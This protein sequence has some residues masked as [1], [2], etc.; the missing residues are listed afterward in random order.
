MKILTEN[1][2]LNM[3]YIPTNTPSTENDNLRIS[4]W[5]GLLNVAALK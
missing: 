2:D 1:P 5:A 4:R 3:S